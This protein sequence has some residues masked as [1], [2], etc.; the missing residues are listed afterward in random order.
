MIRN[1]GALKKWVEGREVGSEG[2]L[3]LMEDLG[4]SSKLAVANE[5]AAFLGTS[6]EPPNESLQL[7]TCLLS[8]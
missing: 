5:S 2:K 6:G 4:C 1:G 3:V 8:S 7:H